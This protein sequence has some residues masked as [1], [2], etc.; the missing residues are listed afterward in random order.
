MSV[1]IENELH[2]EIPDSFNRIIN[3]IV[4]T[5]VNYV[6]CPYPCEINVIFT[7]DK[8]IRD[9]NNEFRNIDAP[10]DV[11]SF[12][13]I[14]YKSPADFN[15]ITPDSVD[16]FNRE[17]GEMILGDIILN[18]DKIKSQAKEYNHSIYRELAFLTAHSMLH[19]FGYDHIDDSERA[20]MEKK[21]EEIL[22]MKGYTRDYE[23]N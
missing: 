21:Q 15:N 1:Y 11:L 20:I 12:P 22:N 5:V 6:N 10:T 19:L 16:Y 23:E 14:D 3:E 18:I 9:I 7:D 17:N 2:Y 8:G 4:D 13:M